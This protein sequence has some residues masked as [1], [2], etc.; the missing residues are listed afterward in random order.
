MCE[1]SRITE[2]EVSNI[3]LNVHC[4]L[5]RIRICKTQRRCRECLAYLYVIALR[6]TLTIVYLL[7]LEALT[8]D[9]NKT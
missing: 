5:K 2:V 9:I 7:A 1:M 6:H 8:V 4:I 3:S